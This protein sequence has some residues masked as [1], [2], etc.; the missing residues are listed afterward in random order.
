MS[1]EVILRRLLD[2]GLVGQ[3]DYERRVGA[4]AGQGDNGGSGGD[5]YLNQAAYLGDRYLS[6]VFSRY[7]QGRIGIDET[8]EY[9]NVKTKSLSRLEEL[10]VQRGIAS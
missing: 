10:A 4:F 1:R 6:L 5:Y 2:H 3:A 8:A 7:Y 9:L